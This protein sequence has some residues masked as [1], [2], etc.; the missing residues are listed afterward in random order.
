MTTT[1]QPPTPFDDRFQRVVEAS[2]AGVIV[3]DAECR[4]L[5][6]NRQ[7][8]TWFQYPRADL[9]G[10][11]I[12]VLVP[13]SI[14]PQHVDLRN[15]YMTAPV[16][17]PIGSGRDLHA[18]RR[19][20]SEFP[21]DVSLHPLPGPAGMQ[22][23]VHIVDTT[24]RRRLDAVK[25][26]QESIRQ[27][28]FMVDNLPAG[29]VY[30]SEAGIAVNRAVEAITGYRSAELPTVAS[31]FGTLFRER[32]AEL[33]EQYRAD[34]QTG[35]PHPRLLELTRKDGQTRWVDMAAYRDGPH[36]LWLL[37]DVTEQRLAQQRLVQG[38]RLAAIGQMMTALAHE[39]R[40]ALQRAQACLEM[41]Q[42]D[43]EG[44]PDLLGLAQ[45][46]QLAL[47]ELE[48]L[49]EEVRG[50]AAPL[51]LELA[52]TSLS[53]LWQQ[54]WSHLATIRGDKDIQFEADDSPDVIELTI[55]AHRMAQ[56][57][58]NILENAISVLPNSGGRIA[59]RSE[60]LR[61]GDQSL[62]R[63]SIHDNG[64]GLSPEQRRRIF[65]P[66]YTTKARGTGLGMAIAQR[67]MEAHGGRITVG[68]GTPGTEIVLEFPRQTTMAH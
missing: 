37:H 63:V 24:E 10:Q 55:D 8:E 20:G 48:R 40:N 41:M 33:L 32:S 22:V 1:D 21:C 47:D 42:L 46:T 50:Y 15:G 12:E 17:R 61:R 26:E 14:R 29:A 4:I 57:L 27:L 49:Y 66:F 54:V 23:M 7:I 6:V 11:F 25:R 18:R 44:Q 19:D 5:L 52:P 68:Q 45:R 60:M 58:R 59:V 56:V 30:V 16:D 64:P 9:V 62:L 36:E 35:F 38:E 65:E 2:P 43:L 51:R 53:R 3:V 39:S 28:R 31:W 67:I 13:D 34:Q